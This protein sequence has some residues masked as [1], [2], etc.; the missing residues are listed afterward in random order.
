MVHSC[1]FVSLRQQGKKKQKKTRV[2]LDS[3][4][5]IPIIEYYCVV[6][7]SARG[8]IDIVCVCVLTETLRASYVVDLIQSLF[9]FV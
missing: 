6:I 3:Q 4:K 7:Q 2:G 1:N 8:L 9:H 5:I